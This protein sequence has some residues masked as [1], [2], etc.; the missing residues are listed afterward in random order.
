MTG[1]DSGLRLGSSLN[2]LPSSSHA[3]VKR[4]IEKIHIMR[5]KQERGSTESLSTESFFN[6]EGRL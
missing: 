1:D 3:I 5:K 4:L 2:R 6:T